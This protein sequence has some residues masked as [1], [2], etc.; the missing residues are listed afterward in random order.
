MLRKMDSYSPYQLFVLIFLFLEGTAILM[1]VG[2]DLGR[3]A[4]LATL[5]C[6]FFGMFLVWWYISLI[7]HSKQKTIY[8]VFKLA[9]GKVGGTLLGVLYITYFLYICARDMRDLT[10]LIKNAVLPALPLEWT[11]LCFMAIIIYVLWIGTQNFIH[12]FMLFGFAFAA[13]L[14]IFFALVIADGNYDFHN[15]LPVLGDGPMSVLPSI[16]T[17]ILEF[18]FGELIAF[19]VIIGTMFPM[20]PSKV[21]KMAMLSVLAAGL[22]LTLTVVVELVTFG[23]SIRERAMFPLVSAARNISIGNFLERIEMFIIFAILLTVVVKVCIFAYAAIQGVAWYSGKPFKSLIIPYVLLT[24]VISFYVSNNM[25]EHINAG[26]RFVPF[27][28]HIPFQFIIPA[29]LFILILIKSRW[30]KPNEQSAV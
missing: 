30:R 12:L 6:T 3:D 9:L 17:Q 28:I 10:E 5:V 13:I 14:A 8:D 25:S 16:F 27:F 29:L 7:R 24:T 26:L 23:P 21:S 22:L 1:N 2:F 18:P 15:L 4:W 19:T 20:L 11:A